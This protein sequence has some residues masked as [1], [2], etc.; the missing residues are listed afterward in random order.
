[1]RSKVNGRK[2]INIFINIYFIFFLIQM[3]VLFFL[4]T[5][6]TS[7]ET[8]DVLINKFN[9]LGYSITS[10]SLGIDF[11]YMDLFYLMMLINGVMFGMIIFKKGNRND[12]IKYGSSLIIGLMI[13]TI[14]FNFIVNNVN[15]YDNINYSI[16]SIQIN[17]T[18][19][20]ENSRPKLMFNSGLLLGTGTLIYIFLND[21]LTK[22][23]LK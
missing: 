15:G 18:A 7:F 10:N 13:I 14:I 4:N 12:V 11:I 3:L 2:I 5:D 22:M 16:S 1:M 9:V 21:K 8:Y 23:N 17:P 20:M 6:V 19:E